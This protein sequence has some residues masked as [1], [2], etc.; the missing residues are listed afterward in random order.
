MFLQV[1]QAAQEMLQPADIVIP[2]LKKLECEIDL[3]II[4]YK[5]AFT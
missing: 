4:S 1:F 5:T 2:Y 3:D